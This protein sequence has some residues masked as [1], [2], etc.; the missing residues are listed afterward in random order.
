MKEKVVIT[1]DELSY[2]I[3]EKSLTNRDS[4]IL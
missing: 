1:R 3:W 4:R 2:N